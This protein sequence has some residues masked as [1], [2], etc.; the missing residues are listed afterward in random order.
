MDADLGDGRT[1]RFVALGRRKA[2]LIGINYTGTRAQL[3]GCI[4][5]AKRMQ[6]LLRGLY[7]FGGGSTDMVVLTDDNPDPIYKPT[8]NNI[9]SVSLLLLM[10]LMLL[11]LVAEMLL[12]PL[13][14]QLSGSS[15]WR[16]F[17]A[18][19]LHAS[20]GRER[21]ERCCAIACMRIYFLYM[22][23]PQIDR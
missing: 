9:L 12:M 23:V 5:D 1:V 4:N 11:L 13:L 15:L 20:T 3:R 16:G 10:I 18:S 7:G 22:F 17:G 2:L 21:E 6:Q 19:F 8:R 14:M